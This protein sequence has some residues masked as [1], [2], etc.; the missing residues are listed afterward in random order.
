M[1]AEK[2]QRG[3][4]WGWILKRFKRRH[5]GDAGGEDKREVNLAVQCI[6][7]VED[8]NAV[9]AHVLRPTHQEPANKNVDDTVG[10]ADRRDSGISCE[11]AAL[12]LLSPQDLNVRD[13]RAGHGGEGRSEELPDKAVDG[14]HSKPASTNATTDSESTDLKDPIAATAPE[15]ADEKMN[16]A[17]LKWV[18]FAARAH[19]A[20]AKEAHPVVKDDPVGT[21]SLHRVG[22]N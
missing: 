21:G 4:N 10:A 8:T 22:R 17:A 1:P 3:K 13:A 12:Q 19:A 14:D 15:S 9:T 20:A 16:Q 18:A 5:D 6:A 7:I 2:S 11:E